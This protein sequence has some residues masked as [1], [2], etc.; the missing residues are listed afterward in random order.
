MFNRIREVFN[1][2][3]SCGSTAPAAAMPITTGS[4]GALV[5]VAGGNAEVAKDIAMHV[6]AKKPEVVAKE[7]LDP[8]AVDKEREILTEAARKEGKPENIIGKMVEGRMK[9]FYAEQVLLGAAVRQGRQEDGRQ[10]G[11]SRPR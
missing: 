8:A 1:L 3:G 11:R 6:A 2:A 10:G 7:D 9:N 5:E 4:S